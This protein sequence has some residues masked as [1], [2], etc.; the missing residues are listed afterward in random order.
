MRS[1]APQLPMDQQQYGGSLGGPL[2]RNRTFFFAN[3]EQR[4]L[5]QSGLVTILAENVPV[6]NARLD[7]PGIRG[8]RSRPASIRIRFITRM[9]SAKLDHHRQRLDHLTLRYTPVSTSHQTTHA[10]PAR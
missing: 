8:H 4:L 7:A 2:V 5:D 9:C 6:I 1:P 10:A 3:F